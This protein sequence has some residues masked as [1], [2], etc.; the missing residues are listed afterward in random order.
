MNS[1]I[2]TYKKFRYLTIIVPD[3]CTDGTLCYRAEHP[4]LPGC[5][6]HGSTKEEAIANLA[7][8]KHL[9]IETL[10]EKKLDV[11][12]PVQPTGGTYSTSESIVFVP[13]KKLVK[14]SVGL[15]SEYDMQQ[16]SEAT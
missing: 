8:A 13:G 3:E 11:P 5:M 16:A 14:P 4:Q 12:V 7:E 15:P 1:S 2:D 9:Y 10:I 6:S